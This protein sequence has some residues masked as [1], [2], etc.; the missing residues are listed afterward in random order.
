M[1]QGEVERTV[2]DAML[3][4]VSWPPAPDCPVR[5]VLDRIG[6]KWSTLLLSLLAHGP[7]R[8]SALQRAIPDISK[9]MLAQ[10][11]HDLQ[12]D[13]LVGREVFPTKPPA[14]EYRLTPL[15]RTIL[16]PLAHLVA[17]ADRHHAA[18]VA[19]RAA[20]DAETRD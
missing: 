7:H 10:T 11:L 13:G 2:P 6:D 8:F 17:W 1:A 19:A 5:N 18:I 14:V 16:E 15:G 9:R 3:R 12:R 4:P 20:F